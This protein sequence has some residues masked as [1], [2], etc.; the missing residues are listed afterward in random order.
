MVLGVGV[1]GGNTDK[2]ISLSINQN[3][4][5]AKSGLNQDLARDETRGIRE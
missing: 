4:Q 5:E 3:D 2:K 1:Y